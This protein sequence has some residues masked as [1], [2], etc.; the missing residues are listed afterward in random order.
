MRHHQVL[1]SLLILQT[2]V[3][4]NAFGQQPYQSAALSLHNQYRAK[5]GSP[6]L[7]SD[8]TLI[9]SAEKCANYYAAKKTIDHTCP[10]KNGAGENL[11]GGAGSWSPG[12]F[13]AMG[14]KMWYD[15]VRYYDFT[16]PGFSMNTGH[17]T[18]VVWKSSTKLGCGVVTK[19]GY[20]AMACLYSPPGNMMGQ[21]PANVLR[22][23]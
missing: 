6:A 5:H 2:L 1:F 8:A 7:K 21:F 3:V 15:E 11:S 14:V 9:A 22:L 4:A 18:A 20:T 17:F 23:R 16:K 19:D 10:F 12:D 13:T